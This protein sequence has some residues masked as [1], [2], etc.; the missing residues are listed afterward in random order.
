MAAWTVLYNDALA[1][2]EAAEPRPSDEVFAVLSWVLQVVD[3]GP[4]DD[5][6]PLPLSE[7]L[8]LSRVQGTGIL[9]TFLALVYER[10][11]VIRSID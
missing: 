3:H 1:T 7:D 5:S 10:R 8:Y 6:L 11:V 9:V 4:P 2:W